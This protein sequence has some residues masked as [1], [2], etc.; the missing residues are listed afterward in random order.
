MRPVARLR[1]QRNMNEAASMAVGKRGTKPVWKYSATIGIPRVR[2]MMAKM[3]AIRL[4]NLS[5]R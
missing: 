5:G 2:P 3:N 4:K 1:P